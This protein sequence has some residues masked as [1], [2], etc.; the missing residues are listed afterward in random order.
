MRGRHDSSTQL[1]AA[2]AKKCLELW[3]KMIV[4]MPLLLLLLLLLFLVATTGELELAAA[5]GWLLD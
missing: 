5:A 1:A 3:G 4:T 2:A